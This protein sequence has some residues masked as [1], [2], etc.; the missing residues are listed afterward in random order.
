MMGLRSSRLVVLLFMC[1]NLSDS[2]SMKA[3]VGY[4]LNFYSSPRFCSVNF[5]QA[6]SFLNLHIQKRF[7]LRTK[8]SESGNVDES[9]SPNLSNS[10]FA[11]IDPSKRK[12]QA[13]SLRSEA[14]RLDE[15]AFKL[16]G[17]ALDLERKAAK[18]RIES[19][20][21]DGSVSEVTNTVNIEDKY[22]RQLAELDLMSEEY[23]DDPEKFEWYRSQRQLLID[24]MG[25]QKEQEAKAD[26][27][28]KELKEALVEIQVSLRVFLSE[29]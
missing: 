3:H 23:I 10:S 7:S 16:R 15:E 22:E 8:M 25:F 11:D 24:M 4:H 26:E 9:L 29:Q 1:P 27:E 18:L 21:L 12:A 14:L 2:L 5:Q 6:K 28:I 19:W 13:S 17:Q 20:K